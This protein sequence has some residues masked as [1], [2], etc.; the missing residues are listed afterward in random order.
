LTIA[1]FHAS[2]GLS[3]KFRRN[4]MNGSDLRING[5][6]LGWLVRC[7]L[8]WE[9]M[10]QVTGRSVEELMTQIE[11]RFYAPTSADVTQGR[12]RRL[13]KQLGGRAL[14]ARR[15]QAHWPTPHGRGGLRSHTGDDVP[16]VIAILF[17][18]EVDG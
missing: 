3:G 5:Q 12:A 2:I 16:C 7:G 8:N 17:L 6:H 4:A 9:Q 10:A 11:E 13:L 14:A 1:G 15:A 18:F